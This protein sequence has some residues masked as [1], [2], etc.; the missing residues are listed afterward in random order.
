[1]TR[2]RTILVG[3]YSPVA[4]WNIPAACVERL[5]AEF[6]R[7]TFLHARSDGEALDMIRD[8]QIAFVADL[9]P[10]HLAAAEHL[11][12]IHSPAAGVGNMLFP[13]MIESRAIMTNS[14]GN[15]ADTIAE[16]V[17]AITLAVFRKLQLAVQS[18]AEQTWAQDATLAGQPLRT[19]AGATVLVVG[20]GSI[21]LATARRMSALGARVIG[22]R[23]QAWLPK[24]EF[25]DRLAPPEALRSLLPAA[26]VVVLA[27]PE[28]SQT[29]HSIGARELAAM[30]RDAVLVNV[31]RGTLVDEGALIA[32]LSA[33][34]AA[35]TIGAA[36][37]DV[38]D[39]EPLAPDSP[40]WR[41]PN[42]LITP[43]VAGFRPDHWDAVTRLFAENL[44]RFESGQPLANVV[45][46]E[47]GY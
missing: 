12:W 24:P 1:V 44:R 28:T 43:H 14:R 5:R 33:P 46:K 4:A 38:F 21:G 3:I 35:R 19:I 20:L 32:A 13:A 30:R 16:H 10:P 36:A 22:I 47:E 39:R 40:L 31:S 9:R 29:R 25:V 26:D 37:L 11:E 18:Q 42:V 8:A 15:S 6:P 27:A 41:L 45:N 34:A 2:A 7:H 23:R 17:L